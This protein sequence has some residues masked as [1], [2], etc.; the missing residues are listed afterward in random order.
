MKCAA[1]DTVGD[2]AVDMAA[3]ASVV[4]TA[5]EDTAELPENSVTNS[6]SSL[7]VGS[8]PPMNNLVEMASYAFGLSLLLLA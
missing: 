8:T 5:V 1:V 2:T 4:D 7:C 6:L 3:A